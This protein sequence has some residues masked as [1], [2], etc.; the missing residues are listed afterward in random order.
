MRVA[1]LGLGEAG[2]IYARGLSS[3][4]VTVRAFDPAVSAPPAGVTLADDGPSAVRDADVVASLVG[5][6]AAPQVASSVFGHMS[7]HAV[8]ADMNTAAPADKQRMAAEAARAG[9]S[10]ADVAVMAP[11]PRA[12]DLTPLLASGPGAA[13]LTDL[14]APLGIPVTDVGPEPGHAAGLKLLRSIFMKGL[15][16][17]VFESVTAAERLDAGD[18]IRGELAGELGNGGADL[19]ERLLSGT[20]QHAQ[21][22][23]HEMQDV[24]AFLY[25]LGAPSWMTASTIRW[26]HAIAAGEV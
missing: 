16:A 17:L 19:I 2:S 23:E 15:A 4:G 9:V 3:R 24:Q 11:V 8:F 18:W 14:W 6:S 20:R 26:L 22:R 21:R 10:F 12:G 7:G 25:T 5:A 13:R 1:V